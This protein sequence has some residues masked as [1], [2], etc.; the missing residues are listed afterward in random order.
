M[1]HNYVDQKMGLIQTDI[2]YI[3]H[4]STLFSVWNYIHRV[5]IYRLAIILYIL[6]IQAKNI[7]SKYLIHLL[8]ILELYMMK[9]QHMS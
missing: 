3:I 6:H 2:L 7:R 8:L 9:L 5:Y 4:F 1:E